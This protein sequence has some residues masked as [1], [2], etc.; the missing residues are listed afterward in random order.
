[1]R[2]VDVVRGGLPVV[3]VV[4][5]VVVVH[6]EREGGYLASRR[7]QR[8]RRWRAR[9][10]AASLTRHGGRFSTPDQVVIALVDLVVVVVVVVVALLLLLLVFF[11]VCVCVC[12]CVCGKK[13]LFF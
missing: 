6:V 8:P 3:V 9:R 4:V 1:M 2:V 11:C 7:T 13:F 5:V 12:V 10:L